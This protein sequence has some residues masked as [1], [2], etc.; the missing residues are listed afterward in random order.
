MQITADDGSYGVQFTS[1][2]V[3]SVT[4]DYTD[5]TTTPATPYYTFHFTQGGISLDIQ[6]A[7]VTSVNGNNL[8]GVFADDMATMFS[9][10]PNT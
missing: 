7:D 8:D 5:Q 3:L 1:G 2:A 10:M 6:N 4:L 9:A